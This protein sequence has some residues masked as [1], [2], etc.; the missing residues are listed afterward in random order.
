MYE[1]D[2]IEIILDVEEMDLEDIEIEEIPH[3]LP[4]IKIYPIDTDIIPES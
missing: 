4:S 1:I 2:E 3:T